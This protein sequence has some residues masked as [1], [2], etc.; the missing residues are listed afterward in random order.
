VSAAQQLVEYMLTDGYLRWLALSPQGKYPARPGDDSDPER[1]ARGWARL[2]SGV[3]RRAPLERFYTRASI[4]SL[5]EGVRSFQ[6]WGFAQ[7]E[8]ALLGALRGPQPISRAVAAAIEG[9]RAPA[10]AAQD[11]QAAVERLRGSTP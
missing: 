6:R 1:F 9:S 10:T 8:G 4:D 2:R 7:G 5:G 11:A 3:E